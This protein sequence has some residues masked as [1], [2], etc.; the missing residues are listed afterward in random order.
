MTIRVRPFLEQ[1]Q[2]LSSVLLKGTVDVARRIITNAALQSFR[3]SW[4]AREWGR[5]PPLEVQFLRHSTLDRTPTADRQC[6]RKQPSLRQDMTTLERASLHGLL[7]WKVN[8][9]R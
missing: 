6:G 4:P 5:A 1:H 7:R 9:A 2:P 3:G 8:F